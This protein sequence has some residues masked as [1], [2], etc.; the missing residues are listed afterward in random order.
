[1]AVKIAWPARARQRTEMDG[2]SKKLRIGSMFATFGFVKM[3]AGQRDNSSTK[4]CSYRVV[5]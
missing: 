3:I 1:L 2:Q 4:A 5:A